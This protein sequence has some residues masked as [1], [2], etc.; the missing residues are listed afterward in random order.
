MDDR[1]YIELCD[2]LE[3]SGAKIAILTK[4][5]DTDWDALIA[6]AEAEYNAIH[7]QIKAEQASWAVKDE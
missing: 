4:H 1:A 7:E 2:R 3:Y 5:R 6:N